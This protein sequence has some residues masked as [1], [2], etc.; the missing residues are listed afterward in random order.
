MVQRTLQRGLK[1]PEA[2]VGTHRWLSLPCR[3]GLPPFAGQR[4]GVPLAGRSGAPFRLTRPP[5]V[6]PLSAEELGSVRGLPRAGLTSAAACAVSK[7]QYRTGGFGVCCVRV[8][9]RS[10]PPRRGRGRSP[11]VA[12][13]LAVDVR[14]R[15]VKAT[16]PALLVGGGGRRWAE[17][18]FLVALGFLRS[19]RTPS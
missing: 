7:K 9:G 3:M 13:V 16:A 12:A 6:C 17:V 5:L 8:G 4:P 10:G 2:V 14:S 11:G 19:S 18:R 1:V 15:R